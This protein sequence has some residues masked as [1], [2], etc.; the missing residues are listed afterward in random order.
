MR[1]EV[2]AVIAPA[3]AANL[4]SCRYQLH[5]TRCCGPGPTQAPG[6]LFKWAE[7]EESVW[8][9]NVTPEGVAH[10]QPLRIVTPKGVLRPALCHASATREGP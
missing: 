8:E 4:S 2:N 9:R 7:V 3:Q 10:L 6:Q 5:G 1:Y